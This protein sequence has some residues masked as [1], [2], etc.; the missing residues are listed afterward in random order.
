MAYGIHGQGWTVLR[1]IA[2]LAVLLLGIVG[3]RASAQQETDARPLVLVADVT[4]AI[5]PA[6]GKHVTDALAV[7]VER[8]AT[9]V[10]LRLNTPGGLATT[11]REIITEIL[12]SPVPVIGHV[13]PSGAHAASAGTY[14]LYATH[15]AAMAPGTNIGAATPVQIGGGGLPL[16]GRDQ[17]GDGERVPDSGEPDGGEPDSGE[18]ASG[19]PAAPKDAMGAKAVNDAVAFIRSLAEMRGRDADWAERAVREAESLSANEALKRGVIELV[20]DDVADLLR[21]ADGRTVSVSGKEVTLATAEARVERHE[22]SWQT[23]LLSILTNPNV[24]FLLLMAG[25]YGLIFEFYQPGSIGP[26]VI[27]ATC[28]VLGLY[29]LN[30][31]PLNYAGLAL[32]L[33]GLGCMVAEAMLP[34]FGILGIGGLVA[35]VLG[36]LLLFETD[37]PEYRLSWPMIGSMA[38]LSG[39]LLV[40]VL[41]YAWKAHRRPVVTGM[42]RYIGQ[43]ADVLDWSGGAGHVRMAG[44]RW[45]AEGPADLS[46]GGRAVVRDIR[47]LTLIVGEAG[48]ERETQT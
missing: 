41:G 8:G 11:M 20:A 25:I 22:I 32:L 33:I 14:I 6:A 17:P 47:G 35:F 10:V 28:L 4:G 34:S 43:E 16:P 9:V 38:A 40:F 31:L 15:L 46:A 18:P 21:Q 23:E 48:S 19:N 24:A 5:G 26:G 13:A 12:A 29:A 1:A 3:L 39:V 45:Q 7:A 37:L 2:A 44:E 42:Q 36:G 27:G 30:L